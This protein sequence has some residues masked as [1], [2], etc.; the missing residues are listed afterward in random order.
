VK[1]IRDD[2]QPDWT[3]SKRYSD[4]LKA[5]KDMVVIGDDISQRTLQPKA[6]FRKKDKNHSSFKL[7]I[8]RKTI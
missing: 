3:V 7:W 5:K 2:D 4:F 8:K 6:E 1:V